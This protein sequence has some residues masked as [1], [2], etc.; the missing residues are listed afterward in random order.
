MGRH[1][2]LR[3]RE[4][5]EKDRCT[6]EAECRRE[7]DAK[8]LQ[9]KTELRYWMPFSNKFLSLQVYKELKRTTTG[10][11]LKNFLYFSNILI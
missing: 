3:T 6:S 5:T 7:K 10:R 1:H 9:D 11:P 2:F 8:D 4:L